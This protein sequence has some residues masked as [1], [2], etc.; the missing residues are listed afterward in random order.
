[1]RR[2]RTGQVQMQDESCTDVGQLMC[3]CGA[4]LI[5]EQRRVEPRTQDVNPLNAEGNAE[6]SGVC[7]VRAMRGVAGFVG[8]GMEQPTCQT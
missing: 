4:S 5:G 2:R 3:R 1:M 6:V 8:A 7:E